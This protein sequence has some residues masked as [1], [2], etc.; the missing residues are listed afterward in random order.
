MKPILSA[1]G[2]VLGFVAGYVVSV[3][4]WEP[5]AVTMIGGA[6][7]GGVL[8]TRLPFATPR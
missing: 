3:V 1:L 5:S 2:A 8:A 4:L 6:I 7:A